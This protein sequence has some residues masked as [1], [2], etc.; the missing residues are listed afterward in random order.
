MNTDLILAA[1]TGVGLLGYLFY[2]LL[3]A[4]KF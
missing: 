1:I 4:E 3:N 2:A